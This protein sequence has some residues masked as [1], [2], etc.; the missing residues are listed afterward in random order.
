MTHP[1][2]ELDKVVVEGDT[3]LD[4]KDGRLGAADKVGGDDLLLGDTET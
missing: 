4:V 1:S 2:D 3:G